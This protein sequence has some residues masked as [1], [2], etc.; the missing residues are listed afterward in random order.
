MAALFRKPEYFWPLL[1][2]TVSV[3]LA[4]ALAAEYFLGGPDAGKGSR[5]P[6]KVADARILP[7]FTLPPEAP[8]GSE[9][10]A[11]PLFV[12]GRRPAPPA[13]PVDAVVM[14]KG[15]FLLQGTTVIGDLSFAMLKEI[16]NGRIHRV[17]KG[18]KVQDMTL[19]EVGPTSAVLTLGSDSE[20]LVLLVAKGSGQPA[21]SDRG[22]FGQGTTPAA[23]P[24]AVPAAPAAARRPGSAA[25]LPANPVAGAQAVSATTPAQ[26]NPGEL[27]EDVLAR[28]RA[29]RRGQAQN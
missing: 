5:Q 16:A 29:A 18:G 26:A 13:A 21:A 19:T 2:G 15:Q 11:R 27:P 10:E 20:T 7:P 22:P 17:P 4:G 23:A 24:G 25:V 6:A 8:G 14:R 9:T 28:R 1:W 3:A 12:P